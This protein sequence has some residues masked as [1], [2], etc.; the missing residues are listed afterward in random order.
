MNNSRGMKAVLVLL[1][2]LDLFAGWAS[3]ASWKQTEDLLEW[4]RDLGGGVEGVIFQS[5]PGMG[6]GVVANR[7]LEVITHHD[8]L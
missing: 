3:A 8:Q 1:V 6:M 4:I 5:I 2:V 7:D